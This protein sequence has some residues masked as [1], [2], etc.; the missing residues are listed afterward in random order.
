MKTFFILYFHLSFVIRVFGLVFKGEDIIN[1]SLRFEVIK[2][3]N[4]LFNIVIE[5]LFFYVI[6]S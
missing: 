3:F 5:I 4:P 2:L 6:L 1:K